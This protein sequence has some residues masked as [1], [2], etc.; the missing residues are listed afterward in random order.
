MFKIILIC[1]LVFRPQISLA[2][3]LA[4]PASVKMD[5][6]RLKNEAFER[7]QHAFEAPIIPQIPLL[8]P[9]FDG[10]PESQ[11]LVYQEELA[12]RSPALVDKNQFYFVARPRLA[13][14]KLPMDVYFDLDNSGFYQ[15]KTWADANP[16]FTAAAIQPAILQ[17]EIPAAGKVLTEIIVGHLSPTGDYPQLFDIRSSGYVRF[18]GF[19][20]KVMGATLRL[21]AHHIFSQ[22]ASEDF[23]I[24][25]KI[26]IATPNSKTASS[27]I[28]LENQLFCA[29]LKMD[30]QPGDG[31]ENTNL[32]VDSHWYARSDFN[33]KSDTHT[34]LVAFSSMFW[35]RTK[36]VGSTLE[37]AAHDSDTFSVRPAKG[38][39]QITPLALPQSGLAIQEMLTDSDQPK[40]W[41]LENV[42]RDPN[43]YVDFNSSLGKT[44]Y[45]FRASYQIEILESNI[46]TGVSLYQLATDQEYADNIVAA[47]TIRQDVPKAKNVAQSI[48]FKY[49]ATAFYPGL[50]IP[51]PLIA[52]ETELDECEFIRSQLLSLPDAGGTIEIPKG[53]FNCRSKI[54]VN[55]S[56]VKIRGAGMAQT[57]LRLQNQSPSPVLVIGADKIKQDT[58]GNWVTET[59]VTDV[60][61]SDLTVDGNLENQ[62]VTKECGNG[63]CDGDIANIRNNAITIRGASYI[64]LS[65]ITTHSAISGGLVTEKY[66]DH[67]HVTDFT[68]YGNHFDGFAGYQTENSLFENVNLSRNHGAGISID[69]QF[70]NN[71]FSGGVLDSNGDVGIF[72]RNLKGNLFENLTIS[73]SGNHGAFFAEAEHPNTCANDNEF[74]SVNFENSKGYGINIAS[75]CTGNKLTGK[76][77][78]SKNSVGCYYVNPATVLA[79]GPEVVCQ[80]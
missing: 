16:D 65:H 27:F 71:I 36:L 28:L 14:N 34:A 20:P 45:N 31:L 59:H 74:R 23:P 80:N 50:E 70:N 8:D 66:C 47:S 61:V 39:L 35:K 11:G 44:N 43:H 25:R 18:A 10:R 40:I 5:M 42:D 75:V 78:F 79:V 6:E 22:G 64:T 21:G 4:P 69:I 1:L 57:I 3:F 68:S 49:K 51:V 37:S 38:N 41:S 60:E 54:L 52:Q 53:T 77:S 13:L 55:K 46:K 67:L 9:P 30:L 48:H 24:I 17:N 62:D 58:N 2:Q 12:V 7:C 15:Q 63:I 19:P 56:H 33:W 32:I 26:F 73:N 76:T 29:A 72:A